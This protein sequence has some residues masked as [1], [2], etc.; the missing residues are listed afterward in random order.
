MRFQ[1]RRSWFFNRSQEGKSR[2]SDLNQEGKIEVQ[3][4]NSGSIRARQ[5]PQ[6]YKM[7]ANARRNCD[8]TYDDNDDSLETKA[9]KLG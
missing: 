6:T 9:D 7:T 1:L 4:R 8:D 3:L 2:P 5:S